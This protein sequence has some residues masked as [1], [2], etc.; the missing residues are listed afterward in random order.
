MAD[1]TISVDIDAKGTKSGASVAKSEIRGVREEAEKTGRSVKSVAERDLAGLDSQLK[2][3]AATSG[4]LSQALARGVAA[5]G[6]YA[7]AIAA[8]V[9]AVVIAIAITAAFII[10]VIEISKAFADYVLKLGNAAEAN[11]LATETMSALRN[12]AEAQGRSISGLDGILDKFRKTIGQAA[13]GSNEARANLKL[14]GIDGSKAIYDIDGAFK[15]ALTS[16]FKLP[17]GIKQMQLGIAAFGDDFVKLLPFFQE[18]HGNIDAVIGKANEL[19]IVIGGKDVTSAREFNRAYDEVHKVVKGLEITFVREFLPGVI[20]GLKEFSKWVVDNKDKIKE[21]AVWAGDWVSYLFG[22]FGLLLEKLAQLKRDFKE[23]GDMELRNQGVYVP[24]PQYTGP[25]QP[26]PPVPTSAIPTVDPAAAAALIDEQARKIEEAQKQAIERAKQG[27]DAAIASWQ[28]NGE[29]AGKVLTETFSKLKEQFDITGNVKQFRDSAQEALSAYKEQIRN[30]SSQLK[31][32]EDEKD[33]RNNVTEAED[34]LRQQ[35]Q[36]DR[37]REWS[38]KGLDVQKD[39]TKA[40]DDLRKKQTA[41]YLKNLETEVNRAQEIREAASATEIAQITRTRNL[42]NITE[43]EMIQQINTAESKA[44]TDRQTALEAYRQKFVAGSEQELHI[45]QQLALLDQQIVQQTITNLDR[46]D[47]ARAE[48]LRPFKELLSGLD[49]EYIDLTI[50]IQEYTTGVQASRVEI[51]KL[52][53]AYK[54]LKSEQQKEAVVKA[55]KIDDDRAI[56]KGLEEQKR[57]YERTFQAIRESLGVLADQGFGAMFKNILHRFK[58]FLLDMVAQWLTSK[59]FELFFK[60]GNSKLANGAGS[61]GVGGSSGGGVG[62]FIQQIFGGGGG[63]GGGLFGGAQPGGLIYNA[64]PGATGASGGYN[65]AASGGGSFLSRLFAGFGAA[66]PAG[67]FPFLGANLGALVGGGRGTSGLLG[68]VGGLLLGGSAFAGLGGLGALF[69]AGAISAGTSAAAFSLLTNP[70]TIAAGVALLVGSYFLKR[71]SLRRKEEKIRAQGLSDAL[72][73]LRTQFDSLINDVRTLRVDPASGIAQGTSLGA[74]VRDQ[75]LQMANSLKDKKTRSHALQ[76]VSQV[77]QLIASKMAELRGVAEIAQAA[78]DR[79]R[80][81]LPEFAKGVYL[82]PA[83]QAFRRYNGLISGA[84]TGRDVLPA[85]L[86]RSEMVLNPRQQTDVIRNAGFDV[87]KTANIPGYAG[88]GVRPSQ[89]VTSASSEPIIVN[90][91]LEFEHYIDAEGMISTQL[92]KSDKVQ[93]N[94]HLVVKDG[95]RNGEIDTRRRGS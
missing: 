22:K 36:V 28:L 63:A 14:L 89:P 86:A 73:T 57:Q 61:V 67:A 51:L 64:V 1:L 3:A 72:S 95:F 76:D 41:D 80:R 52:T 45:K 10:K 12:E 11:G 50:Q 25:L 69:S 91:D 49:Q 33:R 94:L 2:Q 65:G 9:A 48:A 47:A 85:M 66:G 19:G 23:L 20:A 68:G 30:A 70:F 24:P 8:I 87:F 13:A 5:A 31:Q 38:K 92:K 46:V 7:I 54:N 18:F 82:S 17:P 75:Y 60:G 78:G 84:W 39:A 29:E 34:N 93:R 83:F 4:Q 90:V 43:M 59:F 81:L 71:N 53:E 37:I 88:G 6:P 42:G 44:L 35:R 74:Q 32:L 40:I 15:A 58:S 77:D 79:D 56:L 16:I 55:Q 21:W 26:V 27:W 62:G